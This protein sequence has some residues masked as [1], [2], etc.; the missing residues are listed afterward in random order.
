M[1]KVTHRKLMKT[2]KSFLVVIE[3]EAEPKTII[4]LGKPGNNKTRP[5]KVVMNSS[6]DKFNVMSS[7]KK[8]K[9]AEDNFRLLRVTD[10]YT[11][12]ERE[13]IKLWHEK[14]KKKQTSK[15]GEIVKPYTE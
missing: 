8:L 11:Q 9:G 7:L 2:L 3:V 10:D 4:R 6:D 1:G 13:E 12:T 15:K 5:L 14:A